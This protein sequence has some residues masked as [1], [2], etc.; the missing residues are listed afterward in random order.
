MLRLKNS[1][2]IHEN[3]FKTQEQKSKLFAYKNGRN[4]FGN[5]QI[6]KI[7]KMDKKK[8]S[9]NRRN[10]IARTNSSCNIIKSSLNFKAKTFQ[11]D[12]PYFFAEK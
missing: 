5:A 6:T 1:K 11:R 8:F 3:I 9:R 12:E 2:Q 4:K 7:R 10:E